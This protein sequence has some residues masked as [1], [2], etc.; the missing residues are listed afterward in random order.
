LASQKRPTVV[1]AG[2]VALQVHAPT[3]GDPVHAWC[4]PQAAG[5]SAKTQLLPSSLHVETLVLVAQ[6]VAF[7]PPTHS[8]GAALHVQAAVGLL[9]VQL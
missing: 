8:A 1:Q 5:V 6:N 4:V 2:S 7:A 9:P 3:P